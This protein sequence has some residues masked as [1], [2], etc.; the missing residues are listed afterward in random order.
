[1]FYQGYVG[2][3]YMTE[4]TA[5]LYLAQLEDTVDFS[6]IPDKDKESVKSAIRESIHEVKYSSP[7]PVSAGITATF[8]N[9]GH[10]P[11]SASISLNI[12]A[13]DEVYHLLFSGDISS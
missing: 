1:L 9:A 13:D 6:T 4:V 5:E 3:V 2:T 8:F 11:G 10:I 7:V 12:E